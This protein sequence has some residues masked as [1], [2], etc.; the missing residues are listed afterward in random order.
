MFLHKSFLFSLFQFL[1]ELWNLN[2][3][4][5]LNQIY[6]LLRISKDPYLEYDFLI[7]KFKSNKYDLI[8]FFRYSQNSFEVGAVSVFNSSYRLLIKNIS[9]K[10]PVSLLVSFFAQKNL[11]TIK[12]EMNSLRNLIHRG[13]QKTRL[14]FGL[15]SLS[16]TYPILV[17]NEVLE[18]YS[19]GYVD[20][21]G[22]R[23]STSIP[24]YYYDLMNEVQTPLKIFPVAITENV[25]RKFSSEN[26]FNLVDEYYLALPLENS[27]F[28]FAF[29]P[30]MLSKTNEN[31]SWR[32]SFLKYILRFS[33]K[34]C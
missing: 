17:Q 22:Y 14:N 34:F 16:E 9:D 1:N 28:G 7:E 25:L 11:K 5:I 27:I 26:A 23:A 3:K 19:M 15:L 20:A 13:S 21:I 31:L 29:T 4:M 24:F 30:Q 8:S 33:Y 2:F 10:I 18:D 12:N 32:S 6:V